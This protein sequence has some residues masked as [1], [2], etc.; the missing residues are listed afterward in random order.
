MTLSVNSVG[1]CICRGGVGDVHCLEVYVTASLRVV[2]IL[3]LFQYN[4]LC[5]HAGESF[6]SSTYGTRG[7]K[8]ENL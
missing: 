4:M 8:K 7:M 1:K 5:I 6:R 3:V 2:E